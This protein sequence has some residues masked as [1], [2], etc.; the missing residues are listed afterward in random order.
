MCPNNSTADEMFSLDNLKIPTDNS[1]GTPKKTDVVCSLWVFQNCEDE[2]R[3]KLR[4]V[5]S[6]VRNRNNIEWLPITTDGKICIVTFVG[7]YSN[8][9]K[10]RSSVFGLSVESFSFVPESYWVTPPQDIDQFKGFFELIQ[11]DL[12][13]QQKR[14]LQHR[15]MEVKKK[16]V[17]GP[18][19]DYSETETIDLTEKDIDDLRK[20]LKALTSL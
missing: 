15:E 11:S 13:A 1:K 5:V 20:E 17:A 10:L 3:K 12:Q 8:L 16:G 9:I 19:T 6:M 18:H 7:E 14:L 2:N 4:R